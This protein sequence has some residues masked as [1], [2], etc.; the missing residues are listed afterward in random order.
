MA[1]MNSGEEIRDFNRRVLEMTAY[2]RAPEAITPGAPIGDPTSRINALQVSMCW[3][4]LSW[5]NPSAD[6][7]SSEMSVC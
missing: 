1:R 7:Q 4:S 6:K 3:C 2:L 5:N